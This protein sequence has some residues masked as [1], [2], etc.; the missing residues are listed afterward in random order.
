VL[1]AFFLLAFLIPELFDY[2]N[3]LLTLCNLTVILL[4]ISFIKKVK[5]FNKG[6]MTG[7]FRLSKGVFLDV[8]VI[9]LSLRNKPQV[10]YFN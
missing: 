4:I 6:G 8:P 5:F 7:V 10:D 1:C 3:I 9:S 2:L